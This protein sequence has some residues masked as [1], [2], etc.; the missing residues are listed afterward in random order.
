MVYKPKVTKNN[1]SK[2][3]G[4]SDYQRWRCMKALNKL[5]EYSISDMF[6]EPVDPIADGCPDYFEKIE[7]P[8][9]LGTI[10]LKLL[11]NEYKTTDEFKYEVNLVWD[12]SY[13]YN[14]KQAIVSH[15]AKQLSVIFN[16]EAEFF[17]GYDA[18]D[19]KR[20]CEFLEETVGL[21]GVNAKQA[22]LP[23]PPPPVVERKVPPPR[24]KRQVSAPIK[25][26]PMPSKSTRSR[27][28]KKSHVIV[29]SVT[30]VAPERKIEFPKLPPFEIPPLTDEEKE[31]LVTEINSI[32]I[33]DYVDQIFAYIQ[34][35]KPELVKNDAIEESITELDDPSILHLRSIVSDMK[36]HI[37]V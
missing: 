12:N 11:N 37:A 2:M 5:F 29:D 13:K 36:K 19:W 32:Q 15:L 35:V 4:M 10:K 16:K 27:S 21:R 34:N 25:E 24:P 3:T 31:Q 17:T 26:P 8:I 33:Q 22:S 28:S 9:D 18:Y 14:G 23:P 7:H 6:S 20:E 30:P 1:F